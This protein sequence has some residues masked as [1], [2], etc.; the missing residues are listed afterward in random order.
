MRLHEPQKVHLEDL[1]RYIFTEDYIPQLGPNGEHELFFLER[2]GQCP[3]KRYLASMLTPSRCETVHGYD[4]CRCRGESV[5]SFLAPMEHM[6]SA[7]QVAV[8]F[9]E[10]YYD[11]MNNDLRCPRYPTLCYDVEQQM[12]YEFL[13]LDVSLLGSSSISTVLFLMPKMAEFDISC[14]F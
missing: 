11:S 12:T 1:T 8:D 9:W 10:R 5:S 14:L 3:L 6:E 2:S 13:L 4:Q 7:L